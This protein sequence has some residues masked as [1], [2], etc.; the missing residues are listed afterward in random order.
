MALDGTGTSAAFFQ[1]SGVAVSQYGTMLYVADEGNNLVRKIYTSTGVVSTLAGRGESALL[2]GTGTGALFDSV[3]ALAST[4]EDRTVYSVDRSAN[5]V[6]KITTYPEWN[7]EEWSESSRLGPNDE[8]NAVS[9]DAWGNVY[10]V[11]GLNPNGI[12]SSESWSMFLRKINSAGTIKWTFTSSGTGNEL[13]QSVALDDSDSR[14][15][16]VLV[17]GWFSGERTTFGNRLVSATTSDQD[18][19]ILKLSAEGS[20]QWVVAGGGEL[21]DYAFSVAVYDLTGAA[22]A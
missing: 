22:F 16:S 12:P 17:T 14:H 21:G 5:A 20:V 9:V 6:R 10:V 19:F 13:G 8:A 3:W 2:D 1:P 7:T 4:D 11:G 15:P 18:V